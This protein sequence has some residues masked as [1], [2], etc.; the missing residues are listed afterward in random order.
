[1]PPN[2]GTVARI[3]TRVWEAEVPLAFDQSLR[4]AWRS[5]PPNQFECRVG[6]G[7][8]IPTDD[9]LPLPDDPLLASYAQALND[10]GHWAMVVDSAFRVVFITDELRRSQ[11][12]LEGLARVPLGLHYFGSEAM[13]LRALMSHAK[14]DS[15]REQVAA[16][17]PELLAATP[18]GRPELRQ[19]VDPRFHDLID[20]LPDS[21]PRASFA[22]QMATNRSWGIDLN[23][24]YSI[25]RVYATSG[26]VAGYVWIG[27]PAAGMS[28][29]GTMAGGSDLRH[30]E[31][32]QNVV[33]AD[34]RPA[35]ILF[36]DLEASSP[37]AR[38]LATADY[39]TLAR[40]L[41]RA[42]DQ[43]VV[44]AGGLVG[45]HLG[46]GV[47]AFFLA[48]ALGSESAAARAAID[49][50]RTLRNAVAESAERSGLAPD[51]V[52]LRF[53]LHWG[54]TLYVGLIKTVAR[55][56]VTALGDEV[57]EAARIEACASGGRA[58]ASKALI[59]RLNRDDARTLDLERVNYTPLGELTTATE[60][61][62]RDAPA[63]AVCDV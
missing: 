61:A 16:F 1:M 46:D 9:P 23:S 8:G 48:E 59:E 36:A 40:R 11:A 14:A 60:K 55:S 10:A 18:G 52:V 47:T 54:A 34:R 35:A 25:F 44:D 22:F 2:A 29:L 4:C 17:F 49:A 30:L 62:R 53:G 26:Q 19:L 6:Y 31:R 13:A 50:A 45:R 33:T 63:I 58:L 24:W 42:A 20:E 28:M 56:E 12:G 7:R 38:R 43:C 51:D 32:T 21:Q 15:R 57:N 3:G 5:A 41:V 27:K 39:F 37:L